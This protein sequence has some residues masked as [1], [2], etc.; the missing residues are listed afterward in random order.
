MTETADIQIKVLSQPR[1]LCVIRAAVA[2]AVGRIGFSE[3]TVGQVMLAVDE[4]LTNVIRHGY[5][6]RADGPIW[7]ALQPVDDP[8]K[9]GFRIVVED[10]GLQ[11]DPKE[12]CSRDL[13]DLRPGGIGVHII[14]QVMDEVEYTRRAGGGM[15]LVMSKSIPL[16][17]NKP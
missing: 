12:I 2:A 9:P 17:A 5:Q 6:G 7:V 16:A 13:E 4:A 15:K 3:Q 14:R 8:E 10:E 1:Y 11:V